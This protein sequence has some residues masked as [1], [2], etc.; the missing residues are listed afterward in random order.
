MR[1]PASPPE[2]QIAHARTSNRIGEFMRRVFK[3]RERVKWARMTG[4][5]MALFILG[6]VTAATFGG[7]GYAFV[8]SSVSETDTR[9]FLAVGPSISTDKQDYSP[10]STVTLTGHNW[11]SGDSVHVFVNDD[12]G[13]SW[14]YTT[15]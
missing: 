2:R 10:G 7:A 11:D 9:A 15:D 14:S 8:G 12:V 13:Q 5:F 1:R 6:L 3:A 4:A